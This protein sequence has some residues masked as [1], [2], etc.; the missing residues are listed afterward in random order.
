MTISDRFGDG[1]R[2]THRL[3]SL[4]Q[5]LALDTETVLSTY[6]ARVAPWIA[7][8]DA[9]ASWQSEVSDDHTPIELSVT[10]TEGDA[11]LRLLFE[12]QPARPTLDAAREAG[13]AFLDALE[14][15]PGVDLTRFRRVQDLFLPERMHGRFALWISVVFARGAEPEYKVY[16]DPHARGAAEAPALVEEALDRLGLPHA[17]AS[18]RESA[19]RRGP[20]L[21]ET[22]Y[23]ALDLG[24]DPAARVKI[25]VHHHGATP[26]DLVTA[27]ENACNGDAERVHAFARA[28][29]G[30]DAP[31]RVRAPFT[32][33][34]FTATRDAR[35]E[36]TVYVPVCAYAPDDEAV[37]ERVQEYLDREPGVDSRRYRRVLRAAATRPL[38][39]GV[40]LQSWFALRCG[41]RGPRFT[42]YL[43]TE[44][45]RVFAR[46]V[47]PAPSAPAPSP[48][49]NVDVS[50]EALGR[51]P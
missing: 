1:D 23:F 11:A 32:C 27:C 35:A 4:A 10:L 37:A 17:W 45:R 24:S 26:A 2:L 38:A 5:E 49:R 16:L 36:A 12:P 31:M 42:V 13:L 21:D 20:V 25:Y 14:T 7:E 19:L 28:M 47:I 33:H 15:I 40:G 39:A 43:A 34:A 41:A 48:V 8:R 18:L 22:K 6:H 29:R 50:S 44:S 9:C 3:S 46:G 51:E 30:G